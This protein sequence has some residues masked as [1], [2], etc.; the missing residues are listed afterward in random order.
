[1]VYE[2]LRNAI[3]EENIANKIKDYEKIKTPE[4]LKEFLSWNGKKYTGNIEQ[5]TKKYIEKKAEKELNQK[6]EQIRKIEEAE[7]FNQDL[8]IT[9]EWKKSRMWGSNPRAYTNFGFEGE[10]IGGCGY[11]KKST[12]TAQAFN[13]FEPI[14]KL[15]YAKKNEELKVF[16]SNPK[17]IYKNQN[18]SEFY[19]RSQHNINYELF[20]Y[21]SSSNILPYF[22]GGVGVESHERICEALGLQF[23]HVTDTNNTDV[24]IISKKGE[25]DNEN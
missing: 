17:K 12:A 6:L 13:S 7:D 2:E 8:V 9:I 3:K 25:V 23:S 21:G 20:S 18:G 1:M 11:C 15:M 10:S 24:Y 16:N 5:K 4:G 19:G 14:L 22:E